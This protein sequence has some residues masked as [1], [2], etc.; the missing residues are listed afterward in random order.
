MDD[1]GKALERLK[2]ALDAPLDK[3]RLNI[4]AT[5]QRFEFSIEL[6]WKN[7][8]N[9]VEHE[10]REVLSPR[11]A[12]AQ[13]YQMKWIDDEKLWLN[14]LDDRNFV[15][16]NYGQKSADEVYARIKIYYPEMKTSYEKLKDLYDLQVSSS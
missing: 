5:I 6:F 10:K 16:H 11:G 8:K 9:F 7:F 14:M 2:E 13:A 4:D 3:H 12:V 15:S 1:L